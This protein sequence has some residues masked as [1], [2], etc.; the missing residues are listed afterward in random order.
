MDTKFIYRNQ[1][2][3]FMIP[4][5][6]TEALLDFDDN[7]KGQIFQGILMIAKARR[8]DPDYVFNADEI[9]DR[10][11]RMFLRN[12][13][14]LNKTAEDHYRETIAKNSTG[15][16]NSYKRRVPQYTSVDST[17]TDNENDDDSVIDSETEDDSVI[18]TQKEKEKVKEKET[19][20]DN[21]KEGSREKTKKGE[22]KQHTTLSSSQLS[23][24]VTDNFPGM[25]QDQVKALCSSLDS[26]F[27][28]D[29]EE[30]LRFLHHELSKGAVDYKTI[31]HDLLSI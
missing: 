2:F 4:Y 6:Y 3:A 5:E 21:V 30:T 20:R 28:K 8:D 9:K 12:F 14:T 18:E 27:H 15:G 11:I 26:K 23:S 31:C 16:Q 24:V 13:D 19:E 25:N 1:K 10:A 29:E 7:E 17:D 22:H